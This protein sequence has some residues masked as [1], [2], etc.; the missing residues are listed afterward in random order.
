M[1]MTTDEIPLYRFMS[2]SAAQKTMEAGKFRVGKL[3][4]FNDPFEW[5]LGIKNARSPA[6][7][8]WVE[9]IR[10]EHASWF[11]SFMGILCFSEIFSTPVLWSL[12]A[13]KH[14]GAAFELKHPWPKD[15]LIKMTYSDERPVLD[16]DQLRGKVHSDAELD[17]HLR[18]LVD[19]LM[20]QKSQGFAFE[21]EYR[22]HVDL[23]NQ[24]TCEFLDGHH[25]WVPPRSLLKRV[26]LGFSCPLR[27]VDVRRLL[28]KNGFNET[29]LVRAKMSQ[30]TYRI[31]C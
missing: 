21:R 27:E 26:I 18:P 11:D 7:R 29:S 12:Y 13:D 30:E 16:F 6:E 23:K 17:G 28:D 5:K 3:S 9:F 22:L 2:A 25:Y 10:R 24:K 8:D 1:N 31:L 19:R 4:T 20:R 14:A 15:H